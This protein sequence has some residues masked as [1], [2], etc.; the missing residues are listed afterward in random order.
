M[1]QAT[2]TQY[3]L[4]SSSLSQVTFGA[5]ASNVAPNGRMSVRL[6]SNKSYQSGLIILDVAH[7][8]GGI[9]GSWPAFW[10]V[11]PDWPNQGEIGEFAPSL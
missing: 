1:D 10:T 11:G 9:C 7:M 2:A 5:D 4:T 8:P 3:N 6:T